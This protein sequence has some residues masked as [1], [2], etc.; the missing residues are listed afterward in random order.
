[1]NFNLKPIVTEKAVMLIERENVLTFKTEKAATKES[2]K[3]KLNLCSM[4]KLKKL[5]HWLKTTR[6][7]LMLN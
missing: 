7:L 6:S 1:M 4:L 2:I 3:K 5:E